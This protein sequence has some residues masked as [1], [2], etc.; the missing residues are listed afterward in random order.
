MRQPEL[1]LD[2]EYFLLAHDDYTGRP[3]IKA[4]VLGTG[5]AG[6]LLAELLIAGCLDIV[7]GTVQV[8]DLTLAGSAMA[9]AAAEAIQQRFHPVGW[10]VECLRQSAYLSAGEQMA[11]QNLVSPTSTGLFRTVTRHVATDAL[12]AAGPRVRLR[13]AAESI[14]RVP[15]D[16]RAATLA[17]LALTTGLG[18]IIADAANRLVRDGLLAMARSVPPDMRAVVAGVDAA[19]MRMAMATPRGR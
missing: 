9:R 17:A 2:E 16:P 18:G 3:H 19:L 10:W 13:Y 5:L 12:V 4:D 6:A 7:D 11:R 1:R 15:P 8:R 14:Q